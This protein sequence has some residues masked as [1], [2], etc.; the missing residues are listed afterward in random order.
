MPRLRQRLATRTF[1][2][3]A[4]RGAL[5]AQP[6]QNAELQAADHGA[7]AV[8]GN[9]ELDIRVAVEPLERREIGLR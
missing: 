1:F 6:R 8:L 5:R 9:D 3:Q 4:A 7:L 2:D